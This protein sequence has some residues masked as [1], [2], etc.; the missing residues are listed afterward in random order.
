MKRAV[1]PRWQCV[2]F[3]HTPTAMC[4]NSVQVAIKGADVYLALRYH[5]ATIDSVATSVAS[6]PP[7]IRHRIV[8]PNFLA[9][10]CIQRVHPSP[11]ADRVHDTIHDERCGFES[12]VRPQRIIPGRSK[13]TEIGLIDLG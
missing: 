3:P 6:P 2:D 12:P 8:S 9:G 11:V 5:H 4:V 13:S 10:R 1:R 7:P